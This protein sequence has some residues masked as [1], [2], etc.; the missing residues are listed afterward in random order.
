MST[1]QRIE[2]ISKELAEMADKEDFTLIYGELFRHV[3]ENLRSRGY[4]EI[5][6]DNAIL[7]MFG[8]TEVEAWCPECELSF[9]VELSEDATA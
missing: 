4:T 3:K 2:A 6:A 7:N 1:L 8:V 5:R 9:N